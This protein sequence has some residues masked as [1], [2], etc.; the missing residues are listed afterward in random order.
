MKTILL[1]IALIMPTAAL[2]ETGLFIAWPSLRASTLTNWTLQAE[3]I[4]QQ[5]G[6]EIHREGELSGS[7]GPLDWPDLEDFRIYVCS[8]PVLGAILDE[9]AADQLAIR[10]NHPVLIEGPW[11]QLEAPEPTSQA[12]YIVKISHMNN[13]DI[14]QRSGDLEALGAMVAPLANAWHTDG[15]LIPERVHG[16][17]RPDELTFIFYDDPDVADAFRDA[18]PDVLEAVGAFNTNHLTSFIYLGATVSTQ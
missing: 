7:L 2:A 18:N 8:Q 12:E 11:T 17:L 6:C 14:A 13:L 10:S 3:P 15:F 16:T 5:A 9:G 1:A 4:L